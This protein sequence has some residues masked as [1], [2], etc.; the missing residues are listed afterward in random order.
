MP[1]ALPVIKGT[2]GDGQG[3]PEAL[4]TETQNLRPGGAGAAQ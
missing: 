3:G 4:E 1:L 2:E